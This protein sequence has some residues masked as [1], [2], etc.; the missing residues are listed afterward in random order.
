MEALDTRPGPLA[1]HLHRQVALQRCI[2]LA[3]AAILMATAGAAGATQYQWR[4]AG[5]RMVFSDQPPPASVPP[6]RILKAPARVAAAAA[7]PAG[8]AGAAG[9]AGAS[10][11]SP[12]PAASPAT[13]PSTGGAS[14]AADQE[15]A[16]RKRMEER[17]EQEK[18]A[19]EAAERQLKLARAC[20]DAQGDIRALESGQRISRINAAGEREFLSDAERAQRL[21]S[22]RKSVSERC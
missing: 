19:A 7:P 20:A 15:L 5:G 21:S 18:K 22:A 6:A 16:F 17:A 2:L 4:D 3:S 10:P 14:S 1:R 13:A 8:G 11:A 12:P 9:A